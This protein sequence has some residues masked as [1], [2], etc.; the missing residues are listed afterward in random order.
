[1]VGRAWKWKCFWQMETNMRARVLGTQMAL[2]PVGRALMPLV[3][4]SFLVETHPAKW[5]DLPASAAEPG[6]GLLS[7]CSEY[8]YP[9]PFLMQ[10]TFLLSLGALSTMPEPYEGLSSLL[11]QTPGTRCFLAG[12]WLHEDMSI[13]PPSSSACSRSDTSCGL[14]QRHVILLA[15]LP[16]P[17]T[18]RPNWGLRYCLLDPVLC[19]ILPVLLHVPTGQV[20]ALVTPASRFIQVSLAVQTRGLKH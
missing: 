10:N 18:L 17:A 7:L 1:M 15:A 12:P 14:L 6:L 2:A 13:T 20:Q 11:S 3:Q 4:M 16:T 19:L 5:H 8:Y 9:V